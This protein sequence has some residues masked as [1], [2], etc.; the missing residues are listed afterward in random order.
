M[1]ACRS[2]CSAASSSFAR[3]RPALVLRP[4]VA[5][6]PLPPPPCI[7]PTP[8]TC[9]G[10]PASSTTSMPRSSCSAP[11][12]AATRRM[13]AVRARRMC[14][15]QSRAR[16]SRAALR[17]SKRS[18]CG[19]STQPS[20]AAA[21]RGAVV[22]NV[23]RRR[24]PCVP[25]SSS[26]RPP[27]PDGSVALSS[28]GSWPHS[29]STSCAARR[30]LAAAAVRDSRAAWAMCRASVAPADADASAAAVPCCVVA[31]AAFS[32]P[33]ASKLSRRLA[34]GDHTPWRPWVS[35]SAS[36]RACMLAWCCRSDAT[37]ATSWRTRR[38]DRPEGMGSAPPVSSA[39]LASTAALP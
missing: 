25:P 34:G 35:V 39:A 12:A 1:N 37:L 6:A 2:A 11:P 17:R 33:P 19:R 18:P 36:I 20:V 3:H 21:A 10:G 14:A 28:K 15:S 27:A 32:S 26:P 24:A 8:S 13:P 16:A 7:M 38:G 5:A 31:G 4:G 29:S 22:R 9:A 30:S 23:G